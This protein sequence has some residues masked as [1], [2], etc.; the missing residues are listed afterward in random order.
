MLSESKERK[1]FPL[2]D[3]GGRRREG[4]TVYLSLSPSL[5]LH[6]LLGGASV[7]DGG[8]PLQVNLQDG[9]TAPVSTSELKV[10]QLAGG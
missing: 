10:G 9:G 5:S 3:G 2:H 6:F 4:E 1:L 7:T 8:D